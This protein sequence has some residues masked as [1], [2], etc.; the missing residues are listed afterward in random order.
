LGAQYTSVDSG[1]TNNDMDEL[2]LTADTSI[3]GVD[4]SLAFIN[5]TADDKTLDG[6]TVQAYL[7]LPF[8]L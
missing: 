3:G 4:A 1:A 2:T 8:S 6:N 7:T 5:T